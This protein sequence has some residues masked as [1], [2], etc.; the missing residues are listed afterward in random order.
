MPTHVG[1][2][3][4][5][6]FEGATPRRRVAFTPNPLTTPLRDNADP[7]AFTPRTVSGTGVLSYLCA[8]ISLSTQEDDEVDQTEMAPLQEQDAA[9]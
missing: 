1:H 8:I 5:T 9:Q 7:S 6:G 2:G 4:G 3:G